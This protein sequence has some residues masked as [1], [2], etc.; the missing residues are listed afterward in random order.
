MTGTN[1]GNVS[2]TINGA[3]ATINSQSANSLTVQVPPLGTGTHSLT[4]TGPGGTDSIQFGAAPPVLQPPD[5]V[6]IAPTS[7]TAGA[8][9]SLNVTGTN[10]GNVSATINGAA[11]TISSQSANSLVVQVPSLAAGTH[12]FTVTGPDGSDSMT[13]NAVTPTVPP[14][15]Q[16]VT[17]NNGTPAAT[18]NVALAGTGF[19]VGA[20]T[21]AVSGTGVTVGNV[22]VQNANALTATFTIA[23]GATPGT[24]SVTV[25]T[26]AGT[27]L[28]ITFNVNAPLA[29]TSLIPA[30]RVAGSPTFTLDAFGVGFI[31]GSQVSF[32]G[33]RYNAVFVDA[34]H[35]SSSIPASE[36]AATGAFN[37]LVSIP[38]VSNPGSFIDSNALT[39]NVINAA[40]SLSPNPVAAS[41]GNTTPLT[42]SV[43]QAVSASTG[44]DITLVS[45]Q[46]GIA[47]VPATAHINQGAISTTVNVSGATVGV[48]NVTASS[49]GYGNGTTTVNVTA[50]A[51]P[52]VNLSPSALTLS[53]AGISTVTVTRVNSN[54]TVPLTVNLTA[55]R[56]GFFSFPATVTIPALQSSAIVTLTGI[57][58]DGSPPV[59]LTPS[60]TGHQSGLSSLV[61]VELLQLTMTPALLVNPTLSSNL[62]LVLS[63]PA[64]TGGTT[65]TL[66]SSDT[67]VVTVTSSVTIPAGSTQ[68]YGRCER[69]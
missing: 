31:N 52:V 58:P 23:A 44:L 54:N 42:V 38:D 15:L 34:T 53:A 69:C 64:P 28:G 60:A 62:Q 45:D 32:N 8:A 47:S 14:T 1:L 16:S 37:V 11:A 20:T 17:P 6:S 63:N 7:V 65:V 19:V 22:I 50:Q 3:Q 26:N 61:T 55:D 39:F 46:P 68:G 36:I 4:V 21:V 30:Q 51:Q 35:V 13:F 10:L 66:V 67:N 29:L 56:P 33:T 41:V 27:S 59:T 2:V 49:P 9:S 5:I 12:S 40:I 18:V 57:Q 43:N 24:R 25:T 48:A